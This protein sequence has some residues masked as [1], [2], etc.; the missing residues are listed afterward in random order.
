L[1]SRLIAPG[2]AWLRLPAFTGWGASKDFPRPALTT[3]RHRWKQP[4]AANGDEPSSGSPPLGQTSHQELA[5][6]QPHDSVTESSIERF[7]RELRAL[8]GEFERCNRAELM[9]RVLG[10]L[11]QRGISTLAAWEDEYFPSGLLDGLSFRGIA[12]THKPDAGALAGLTGA[13]AAIA[14]TGSLLLCGGPGRPLSTS[15]LPEIHMVLLHAEDIRDNL[16]QV[17]E[18][19]E[20]KQASAAVLITGPSRTADIE[21]TLTIGV[22]GPGEVIVFCLTDAE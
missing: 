10:R 2:S 18:L 19:E 22:H 4:Q 7:A 21:M 20:L 5:R 9:D 17:M 1:V 13:S 6:E 8:G 16:T 3:F 15:L 14:E 12:I 11:E